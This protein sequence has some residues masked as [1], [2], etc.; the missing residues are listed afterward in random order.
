[1]LCALCSVLCALCSVLC[2][3]CSV[4]CALF[5]GYCL[6]STVYCLLSTVYV[7]VCC[8]VSVPSTALRTISFALSSVLCH[9]SSVC[10]A[11]CA[12]HCPLPTARRWLTSLSPPSYSICSSIPTSIPPV[13]DVS[14]HIGG[15]ELPRQQRRVPRLLHA[16]RELAVLP[17]R[18]TSQNS[19]RQPGHAAAE[20]ARGEVYLA[21][22][23]CGDY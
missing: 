17:R 5:S 20:R 10:C 18:I 22:A 4:L 14:R 15:H 2:A 13:A 8:N 3:L 11:L 1:V 21:V 6:L 19:L 16:Q 12:A 9:M 7:Y 23:A